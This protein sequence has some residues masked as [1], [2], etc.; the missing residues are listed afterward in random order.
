[1]PFRIMI[2]II[3]CLNAFINLSFYDNLLNA[4]KRERDK[5]IPQQ[6]EKSV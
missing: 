3:G 2:M 1:M 6:R 5:I 4:S